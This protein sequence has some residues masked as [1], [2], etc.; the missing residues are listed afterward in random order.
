[1]KIHLLLTPQEHAM[2]GST[3]GEEFT[4][5]LDYY[6]PLGVL[7]GNFDDFEDCDK[8]RRMERAFEAYP[9]YFDAPGKIGRATLSALN[10]DNRDPN[11]GCTL[12]DPVLIRSEG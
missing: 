2:I 4:K 5:G 6:R 11:Y 1:M 7:Q 3:V 8:L 9:F 12:F 10:L